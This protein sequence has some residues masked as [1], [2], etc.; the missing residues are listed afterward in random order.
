MQASREQW[1]VERIARVLR[2]LWEDARRMDATRASMRADRMEIESADALWRFGR[3]P[4]EK[5]FWEELQ[6]ELAWAGERRRRVQGA[7]VLGSCGGSCAWRCILRQRRGNHA[8]KLQLARREMLAQREGMD[9]QGA[10]L[11]RKSVGPKRVALQSWCRRMD[12]R[13]AASGKAASRLLRRARPAGLPRVKRVRRCCERR[14]RGRRGG[15]R[16]RVPHQGARKWRSCGGAC[17]WKRAERQRHG[18]RAAKLHE[19]LRAARRAGLSCVKGVRR[20]CARRRRQL[21]R[22]RGWCCRRVVL[23]TGKWET[24]AQWGAACRARGF[25][26]GWCASAPWATWR[27]RA[28]AAAVTLAE[29]RP[30]LGT[31]RRK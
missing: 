6:P 12:E 20:C 31:W 26:P 1:K 17:A 13:V 14:H 29:V 16:R 15:R 3:N 21:A 23:H 2:R 27:R 28:L 24:F 9:C 11:G 30:H 4:G 8:A 22:R 18:L 5:M 19:S 10:S 25:D 7:D